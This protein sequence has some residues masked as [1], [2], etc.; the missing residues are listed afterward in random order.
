LTFSIGFDLSNWLNNGLNGA[1]SG[2]LFFGL[3]FGM[4]H[5]GAF[6]FTHY[7]TRLILYRSHQFPWN[8]VAFLNYCTDRIF[9]HRV[10]G[11]Y[12][13]IHRMLMEHFAAMGTDE[14][15]SKAADSPAPI[16]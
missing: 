12:I 10:G 5:G 7:L 9:L 1:L 8:I 11:G 6:I 2:G 16:E 13:F 15:R 14:A 4:H 3:I